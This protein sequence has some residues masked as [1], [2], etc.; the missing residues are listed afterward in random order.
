[1]DA[2]ELSLCI[3]CLQHADAHQAA[4]VKRLQRESRGSMLPAPVPVVDIGG[5]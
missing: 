4:L 5:V 1:M 3:V 2:G